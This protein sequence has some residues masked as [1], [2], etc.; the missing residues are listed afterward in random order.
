M[1]LDS[2]WKDEQLKFLEKQKERLPDRGPVEAKA[3][4]VKARPRIKF[5]GPYTRE[6]SLMFEIQDDSGKSRTVKAMHAPM[7]N[8]ALG[9]LGAQPVKYNKVALRQQM[10]EHPVGTVFEQAAVNFLT[11]QVKLFRTLN[12]SLQGFAVY[13]DVFRSPGRKRYNNQFYAREILEYL[14][15][16][17][18]LL[19]PTCRCLHR[20]EDERA[21]ELGV[22][23]PRTNPE[24]RTTLRD[25][26]CTL[27]RARSARTAKE[28][29][30]EIAVGDIHALEGFEEVLREHS[31]M[32]VMDG[33]GGEPLFAFKATFEAVT[34]KQEL[35]QLVNQSE[36]GLKE[37]T[38]K[39]T[40]NG[41]KADVAR[42]VEEKEVFSME[43]GETKQLVLYPRRANLELEVDED[44]VAL[45]RQHAPTFSKT[46]TQDLDRLLTLASLVP[47]KQAKPE[48]VKRKKGVGVKRRRNAKVNHHGHLLLPSSRQKLASLK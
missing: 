28:L 36:L 18:S 34:S 13:D 1:S 32:V 40:Y 17:H 19:E 4:P 21:R 41:V 39:D 38:E 26:E 35:L 20:M 37:P 12:D 6:A 29:G 30:Q 44:I 27:S 22:T 7:N 2:S 15:R 42:L 16:G 10:G 47:S 9:H 43:A 45:W 25:G 24:E 33:P 11:G 3:A 23:L 46:T 31:K 48:I 14:Q 5:P 8:N